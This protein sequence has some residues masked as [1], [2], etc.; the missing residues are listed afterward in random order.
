V[1]DHAPER[2]PLDRALPGWAV[3]AIRDGIRSNDARKV[4]GK[5]LDIAMS[6]KRRGYTEQQYVDAIANANSGLW[7]QLMKRRD[8]RTSS[9]PRAYKE[10]R[11]AWAAGLVNVQNVGIRTRE[12]IGDDAVELAYE[13][14]DRLDARTDSLSA[15]ETAVMTY[16][17]QQ[18]IARRMLRVTCPGREVAEHAGMPHRTAARVLAALVDRG[19]L[20]KH[21]AGMRGEPGKGRAAIFGLR[22]PAALV[23]HRHGEVPLCANGEATQNHENTATPEASAPRTPDPEQVAHRGTPDAETPDV[24]H[25]G[26]PGLRPWMHEIA[27]VLHAYG[28]SVDAIPVDRWAEVAA[29][30][31]TGISPRAV[32]DQLATEQTA[33]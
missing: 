15:Q 7:A 14:S 19:V 24:A 28:I 17:I 8:G 18:T 1:P 32:A 22:D 13:W 10:L 12:E 29:Q 4:W 33:A 6:A 3:D 2:P 21:S 5:C 27:D 30:Y 16:V 9:M 20:V 31:S 25:R 26:T 11:K 23:A